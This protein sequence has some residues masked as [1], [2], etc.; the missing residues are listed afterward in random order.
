MLNE[1]LDVGGHYLIVIRDGS[2]VRVS[3]PDCGVRYSCAIQADAPEAAS[4]FVDRALDRYV[5]RTCDGVRLQLL[6][7]QVML[8]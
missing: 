3:C 8:T 2:R 4:R 5:D 1:R 7:E 6:A